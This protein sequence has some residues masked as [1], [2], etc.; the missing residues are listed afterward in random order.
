MP[1]LENNQK[2]ARLKFVLSK[3]DSATSMFNNFESTI[4]IIIIIIV[5]CSAHKL[6]MKI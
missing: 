2:L 3:I 5:N 4:K 1:A 6:S